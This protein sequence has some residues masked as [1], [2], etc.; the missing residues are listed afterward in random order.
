MIKF[1]TPHVSIKD[2]YNVCVSMMG[3]IL[4]AHEVVD[5]RVDS[6]VEVA[7]PMG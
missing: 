6:T 2:I 4:T 7:Q 5:D 1:K 3:C